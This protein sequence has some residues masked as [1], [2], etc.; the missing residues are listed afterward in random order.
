MALPP[1]KANSA[2]EEMITLIIQICATNT[3]CWTKQVQRCIY[4]YLYGNLKLLVRK[5]ASLG[6]CR[7]SDERG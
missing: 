3:S 6:I 4:S 1:F 5:I 2:L 7:S